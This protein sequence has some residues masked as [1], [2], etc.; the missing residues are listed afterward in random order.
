MAI[1]PAVIVFRIR[2]EKLLFSGLGG[3][4]REMSS[5]ASENKSAQSGA[6]VRFHYVPPKA[7]ARDA[8]RAIRAH[9]M[10]DKITTVPKTKIGSR[11]GR[12]DDEDIVLL[13]RAILVFLGRAGM[14]AR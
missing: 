3:V 12:L 13:N 10:A 9:K 6:L 8:G 2:I 4:H 14:R 7:K 1:V 5:P 11:V